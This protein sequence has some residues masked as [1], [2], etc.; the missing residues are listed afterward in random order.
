MFQH[1][2]ATTCEIYTSREK[3]VREREREKMVNVVYEMAR[4]LN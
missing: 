1:N 3:R 4:V 2:T